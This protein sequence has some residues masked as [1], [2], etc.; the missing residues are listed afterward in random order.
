VTT[1]RSA[2]RLEEGP[3]GPETRIVTTFRAPADR[4]VYLENCNGAINVGLQRLEG[5]EWVYAWSVEMN[6]CLSEAI[7][8]QPGESRTETIVV[9]SGVDAVVS[10]RRTE[11]KVGAGTYR[12]I[13]LGVY[14]SYDIRKPP[15][16]GVP[17]SVEQRVSAPFPIAEAEERDRSMTSPRERPAEI[18]S[19]EPEHGSSA[20]PAVAVAVT[21][22]TRSGVR[23]RG[24][25]RVY[26]DGEDIT[27]HVRAIATIDELRLEYRPAEPLPPGQHE[28][29]TVY[30]DEEGR[31][32]WYSWFFTV[33]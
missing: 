27:E 28:G 29:R 19:V 6:A 3:Y 4:P 24:A 7:V 31:T 8:M 15:P 12:V 20:S 5:S 30:M 33:R 13:W 11:T 21:F 17:L 10:S 9:A 26:V 1:D 22:A 25:P 18:R 2:Y 14:T 23:L 32:R 16:Y